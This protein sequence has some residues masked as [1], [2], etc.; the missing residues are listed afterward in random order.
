MT[1]NGETSSRGDEI[2]L[3][4]ELELDL[5]IGAMGKVVRLLF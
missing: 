5:T 1:V 4:V 3:K 2:K